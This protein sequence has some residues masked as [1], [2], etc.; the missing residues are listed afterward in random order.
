MLALS[1]KDAVKAVA[2]SNKLNELVNMIKGLPSDRSRAATWIL[3]N[4]VL[5]KHIVDTQ[6]VDFLFQMVSRH[7]QGQPLVKNR[8]VVEILIN[9]GYVDRI[10]ESAEKSAEADLLI[11]SLGGSP[12]AIKFYTTNGRVNDL[13]KAFERL[14]PSRH[15]DEALRTLFL[16]P[17]TIFALFRERGVEQTMQL[18]DLIQYPAFVT[19]ARSNAL[20]ALSEIETLSEAKSRQ[21]LADIQGNGYVDMS[22]CLKL[23]QGSAGEQLIAAGLLPEIKALF[24]KVRVPGGQR[25]NKSLDMFYSSETVIKYLNENDRIGEFMQHAK[26]II[27][28]NDVGQFARQSIA[29]Q[30]GC[31]VLLASTKFA[32]FASLFD[33]FSDYNKNQFWQSFCANRH[34]IDYLSYS[35]DV[36]A[37]IQHLKKHVPSIIDRLIVQIAQSE[38]LDNIVRN[39]KVVN[40]VVECL[41][42]VKPDTRNNLA[43]KLSR[44]SSALWAMVET[45]QWESLTA[46]IDSGKNDRWPMEHWGTCASYQGGLISSLISLD[47]YGKVSEVLDKSS[48]SDWHRAW[49]DLWLR[50]SRGTIDEDINRAEASSA[51]L[52]Q[53][54]WSWLS[55]AHRAQG[56]Y[57]KALEAARNSDRHS[58]Q[59][60]IAIEKR[61]WPEV[62][63][64]LEKSA[65]P[66]GYI[67][68]SNQDGLNLE[69]QAMLMVARLYAERHDQLL[70]PSEA[71]SKIRTESNDPHLQSRCCDALILGQQFESALAFL[72]QRSIPRALRFRLQQ[73]KYAEAIEMVKWDPANP[74]AFLTW[75]R[76]STS[77]PRAAMES[78]VD[79]LHAFKLS[80][81]HDDMQVLHKAVIASQPIRFDAPA[82]PWQPSYEM[83]DYARELY[84]H[85]L[86]D[87]YWPSLEHINA[88]APVMALALSTG[89]RDDLE[90]TLQVSLPRVIQWAENNS[91]AA[92]ERRAAIESMRLVDDVIRTNSVKKS[93]LD[94]WVDLVTASAKNGSRLINEAVAVGIVCLRQGRMDDAKRIL[95]P[96]EETHWVASLALARD[97][98]KRKDWDHAAVHYD[99]LYRSSR[100]RI[101]GLYFSGMAM[102]RAGRADEGEAVMARA[103]K[104]AYHPRTLL[105]MGV[106]SLE[107]GEDETGKAFFEKVFR[108]ALPHDPAQMEAIGHLKAC[109]SSPEEVI[110]WSQQ[111]QML[112]AR[113]HYGY[114][115]QAEFLEVPWAKHGAMAER[116][117][118][119]QDWPA[120]DQALKVCFE[121]KPG[122]AGF[123]SEWVER[124]KQAGQNDL[125]TVWKTKLGGEVVS[126]D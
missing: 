52:S 105:Q 112:H 68:P 58:F 81:R 82:G 93:H 96:L 28:P 26:S 21:L 34:V 120:V 76:S 31:R 46:I 67:Q 77:N 19:R 57:I 43:S 65:A 103:R 113:Y 27:D 71:I 101:E 50:A 64:L 86:F 124:L 1:T 119:A 47:Q 116:G 78:T 15:R 80:K 16:H 63:S 73:G 14:K 87:L 125:A 8:G 123:F 79:L 97:A 42:T 22:E 56:D 88:P 60:S 44:H 84:R 90:R 35:D 106:E 20:L 24:S 9:H 18:I 85:E 108:L 61:D 29:H 111:W 53:G 11:A 104:A 12:T 100:A 126:N 115:D 33:D 10:L 51:T 89:A 70:G 107:I 39:K 5:L 38:S 55:W 118:A 117:F 59:T 32:D 36:D 54:Q 62:V 98:W 2:D 92:D 114:G 37:M 121:I 3:G 30:G 122:E 109:A 72:D 74:R 91:M 83:I 40:H 25:V 95:I 4:P 17:E 41:A 75:I 66:Q 99:R 94:A 48:D 102:T 6:Q 69:H 13:V 49:Y 7:P 23:V 45:D 110:K